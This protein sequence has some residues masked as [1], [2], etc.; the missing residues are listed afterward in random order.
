MEVWRRGALLGIVAMMGSQSTGPRLVVPDMPDLL[1]RVRHTI[2]LLPSPTTTETWYFKGARQ[3]H[4]ISSISEPGR[5]H[6]SVALAQCD[7]RRLVEINTEAGLYGVTVI[8]DPAEYLAR[9]R[10]TMPRIAPLP[11]E[12]GPAVLIT[13]ESTDTGERRSFGS[14]VAR[15]VITRRKTS[16]SPGARTPAGLETTDGWYIDLPPQSCEDWGPATGVLFAYLDGEPRDKVRVEEHGA[17]PTGYPIEYTHRMEDSVDVFVEKQELVEWSAAPLDARLFEIPRGYRP[18]LPLPGG[19]VD[20]MR[21]DTLANR[22]A[23][24]WE[25]TVGWVRSVLR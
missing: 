24:Y 16:P 4:E 3:R 23:A 10:Q 14:Y 2:D 19:G 15:R 20:M 13:L 1:V 11:P 21:P 9:L 7:R 22:I 17:R 12:T 6:T 18:A 8:E 25:M 5:T